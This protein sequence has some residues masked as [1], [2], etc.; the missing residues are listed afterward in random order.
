MAMFQFAK[1][2]QAQ[3]SPNGG[4]WRPLRR[5]TI[6]THEDG[7]P[8]VALHFLA[9][10]KPMKL[11]DHEFQVGDLDPRLGGAETACVAFIPAPGT[12]TQD[13][14]TVPMGVYPQFRQKSTYDENTRKRTYLQEWETDRGP[15]GFV[16][17][18]AKVLVD[19]DVKYM[20]PTSKLYLDLNAVCHLADWVDGPP[21]SEEEQAAVAETETAK[22]ELDLEGLPC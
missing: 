15:F 14:L 17:R 8:A 4:R 9:L 18:A 19:G 16:C 13:F 7:S 6:H 5:E 1:N 11:G 20:D 12:G 10:E 2:P 21:A 22:A 3:Q